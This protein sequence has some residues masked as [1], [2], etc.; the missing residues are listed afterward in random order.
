MKSIFGLGRRQEAEG[1]YRCGDGG[2]IRLTV[3]KFESHP[4]VSGHASFSVL[5]KND[6]ARAWD[7][8][9][10]VL[11]WKRKESSGKEIILEDQNAL[12]LPPL[13]AGETKVI[14]GSVL[15]PVNGAWNVDIEFHIVTVDGRNWQSSA[16]PVTLRRRVLGQSA[17][18]VPADFD[19]EVMYRRRFVGNRAMIQLNEGNLLAAFFKNDFDVQELHSTN[20]NEQCRRVIYKLTVRGASSGGT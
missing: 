7:P 12:D 16:L 5:L 17:E 20:W 3:R 9:R 13:R 6:G 8:S 4:R 2:S 10:L 14:K 11:R 15:V 18:E 1:S 19:Y